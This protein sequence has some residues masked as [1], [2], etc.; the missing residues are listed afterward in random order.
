MKENTHMSCTKL[1][2]KVRC[3]VSP[4]LYL[5]NIVIVMLGPMRGGDLIAIVNTNG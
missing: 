4:I 2:F 1:N 5:K 3:K